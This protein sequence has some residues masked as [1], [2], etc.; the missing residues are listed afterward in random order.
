VTTQ[1]ER[2]ATT[3]AALMQSARRRFGADGFDNVTIDQLA[4]D[5]GATRGALYHHFE[6]KEALFET[7]FR[8]VEDDLLKAVRAAAGSES[9]SRKALAVACKGYIHSARK[10]TVARIVLLDA[11]SVLGW[12]TYRHIDESYFLGGLV[13]AVKAIRPGQSS[14]STELVARSIFA[15]VCELAL[16]SSK[17]RRAA[18]ETDEVVDLLIS[19]L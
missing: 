18:T 16:Q 10:P 15:A 17:S 11:P 8:Q 7:V 14:R 3:R 9:D 6:S 4:A 12:S 5:A 19:A 13:D 2:R 1:A